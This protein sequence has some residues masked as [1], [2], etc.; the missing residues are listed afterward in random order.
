MEE[1][2]VSTHVDVTAAEWTSGERF[3]GPGAVYDGK[4]IIQLKILSDRRN[5]GGGI[6]WLGKF[7]PPPGKLIKIVATALSDEH[8][9]NL[10]GGRATKSGRPARSSGG[11]SLNSTGQPHSAMI[12]HETVSLIVYTGEPDKIVSLEVV[13]LSGVTRPLAARSGNHPADRAAIRA[14]T[15]DDLDLLWN[16]LAIAG[17]EPDVTTA[18]AVPFVAAH[19]AQWQRL[20]DFGFIAERDGSAIGAA[21]ARQ[22]SPDEQPAFYVDE[23]TPEVTIG[24]SAQ[25]RGQGVGEAL[26]HALIA[27]AERR[28]IRLCLNVRHDNPAQRLYERMGF[29]MVPGSA[30]PNRV[31]GLSLGM[32]FGRGAVN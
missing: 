29:R 13:D 9:F 12:A 8:V 26:L 20:S 28:R 6:A 23:R 4:N 5:E 25:A 16:F 21:W 10:E 3:Y 11:Y 17:Y 27:E 14:A 2:M 30:V 24:V 18:R 22:F 15:Q 7:S 32:I 1:S 31:G 19:L